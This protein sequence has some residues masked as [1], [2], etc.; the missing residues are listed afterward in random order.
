MQQKPSALIKPTLDTTFHIDYSWWNRAEGEDLHTYLLSHVAP[1]QRERLSQNTDERTIDYIDPETGEVSQ[2]DEL[3]LALQLAA[4]EP[5]FIN[6]HTSVVD[7]IFRVFLANGNTPMTPK[8]LGD[9]IGRSPTVILKTVSGGRVYK[10]I[11]PVE[12]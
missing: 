11:R 8:E 7:S 4:R 1:E 3:Q 12:S 2:L 10:G 5:D 6:P 9:A